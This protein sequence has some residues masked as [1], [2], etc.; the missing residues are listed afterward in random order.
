[1]K[2]AELSLIAGAL[3]RLKIS[4]LGPTEQKKVTESVFKVMQAASKST[5]TG[6][7]QRV[8][9]A[10]DLSRGEMTPPRATR[11]SDPVA[12]RA[13]L[14]GA[15]QATTTPPR[16]PVSVFEIISATTPTTPI[17]DPVEIAPAPLDVG[18]RCK[19]MQTL[20]N[21]LCEEKKLTPYFIAYLSTDTAA[22][23]NDLRMLRRE[24]HLGGRKAIMNWC[25][26]EPGLLW[27]N[28]TIE[29]VLEIC[30]TVRVE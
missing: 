6:P 10:V 7:V 18:Q 4:A 11:R 15:C 23:R 17:F 8:W 9:G 2:D 16:A 30:T 14:S 21:H 19:E 26:P 25:E 3:A 24:L 29:S 27:N 28:W 5:E 22:A 12:K 20:I 1:M 13:R